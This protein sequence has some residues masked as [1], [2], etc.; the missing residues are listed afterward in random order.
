[1]THTALAVASK[2]IDMANKKNDTVTPMQLLKLVYLSHG[3]LLGLHGRHLVK[4]D[5]EAWLYGPVIPELYHH[6]KDFKSNPVKDLNA[7][8][9]DF[10]SIEDSVIRQVYNG[11]GQFTGPQ[12]SS[13]THR[14][15]SPWHTTWTQ[16][17][18]NSLISNDL[19]E[20]YYKSRAHGVR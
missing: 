15:G 13:L 17:G 6:I 2:I 16:Y 8:T 18:K 9:E 11:Y 7:L 5:I 4:E 1:M 14:E 12:L 19:I 10:D 20:Q 3:W